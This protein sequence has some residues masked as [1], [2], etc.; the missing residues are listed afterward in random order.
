M[1]YL[2]VIAICSTL[3]GTMTCEEPHYDMLHSYKSF[4]ECMKEVYIDAAIMIDKMEEEYVT[5][6]QIGLRIGCFPDH[7][8][9]TDV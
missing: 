8:E 4:G 9:M 5:E 3:G 7:R 6:N 2:A 1:D